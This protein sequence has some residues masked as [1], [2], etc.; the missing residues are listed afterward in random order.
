MA[1][2][3]RDRAFGR[4]VTALRKAAGFESQ[5]AL[6]RALG[7]SVFTISRYERGESKPS[8][9]DLYRLA[10]EL[11]TTASELLDGWPA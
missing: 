1:P 7:M 6:A 4:R 9:D 11:H 5:E 2:S 10:A 3:D 8:I